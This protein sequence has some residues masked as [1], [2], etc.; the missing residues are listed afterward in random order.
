[1]HALGAYAR[2]RNGIAASGFQQGDKGGGHVTGKGNGNPDKRNPEPVPPG[3]PQVER[4]D[5]NIQN[6]KEMTGLQQVEVTGDQENIDQP[7]VHDTN[8][9]TGVETHPRLPDGGAFRQKHWRIPHLVI[10]RRGC[11]Q[12]FTGEESVQQVNAAQQEH[13]EGPGDPEVYGDHGLVCSMREMVKTMLGFL[14]RQ[15]AF[16]ADLFFG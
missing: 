1:M 11:R 2:W 3:Q 5:P 13:D 12:K 6:V 7:E 9:V 16:T 8:A 15:A 14:C 10:K 4:N